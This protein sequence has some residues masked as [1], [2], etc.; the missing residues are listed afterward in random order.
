MPF[1]SNNHVVFRIKVEKGEDPNPAT[2]GRKGHS[3]LP[4]ITARMA[5]SS[6]IR[7]KATPVSTLK[8]KDILNSCGYSTDGI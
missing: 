5:I 6:G 1:T 7:I 8:K 3:F 4:A 2:A